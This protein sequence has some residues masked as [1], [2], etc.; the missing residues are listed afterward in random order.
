M[1]L[2][3]TFALPTIQYFTG[4]SGHIWPWFVCR[5]IYPCFVWWLCGERRDC[6]EI[7]GRSRTKREAILRSHGNYSIFLSL[8]VY[9]EREG[10]I[11][12]IW[13]QPFLSLARSTP[14]NQHISKLITSLPTALQQSRQVSPLTVTVSAFYSNFCTE[15]IKLNILT[16]EP[17]QRERCNYCCT[18]TL[19]T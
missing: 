10:E 6:G 5:S 1:T 7:H 4:S 11:N 18:S 13:H 9:L 2:H 19:N 17:S 16:L 8:P 15:S 12:G 14:I 3:G